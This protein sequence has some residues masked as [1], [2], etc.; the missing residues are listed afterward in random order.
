LAKSQI[1]V[2]ERCRPAIEKGEKLK[3][4][5]AYTK[6]VEEIIQTLNTGNEGLTTSQVDEM[7]TKYGS[8]V[9][10]EVRS[11]SPLKILLQQFN[12]FLIWILL[13]AAILSAILDKAESAIVIAVVILVNAVLGTVQHL[14]AEE[15]LAALK[16]LSSPTAKVIRAGATITIDSQELVVGDILA[17]E[18]GDFIAAD[19][20]IISSFSLK[21]DESALTGESVSVE[22]DSKIIERYDLGPGDQ[23]NMVFSGTH[24]TYGR[25]QAVVTAVGLKTELGKI[26][27][28]LDQAKE[29]K[30]PLQ[31]SLDN[32]GR[33]LAIII[34]AISA[35][36]FAM[37]I[38]RG[39]P[40]L[41]AVMFSVS[42]AV[43]AIPEALSSIVTIVLA[44]GTRKMARENAIIRRLHAVE[45]LGSVSVICSDKTGT[46]TQN[47][48]SVQKAYIRG[49]IFT[50]DALDLDQKQDRSLLEIA[51]LCN[52]SITTENGEIGDPTELALVD[53]GEIY[54]LDE[55]KMRG[56]YKRISELPFD[57]ER[58]LMSTLHEI[59]GKR[60]MVAKGGVDVMLRRVSFIDEGSGQR[61]IT[62]EDI[63]RIER[64]NKQLSSEGL[65]V[66]AFALKDYTGSELE[67]GDE[68]NM[69]IIGLVAMMD[70]P[71]PESKSAVEACHDAGIRTVMITGDHVVT[72]SAIARQ[73]GILDDDSKAVEGSV[74]EKLDDR[75]LRELVSKTSVYARVSPEHKIRI[76]KAWQQ[77]GHAVAMTGDG[78][79]DAPAL[80]QADVGVAMGITGT[81]VSKDAAS[82]VLADDNFATIVKAV[83]N[84]R[85]TY[86]NISNAVQFLL[87]GNAAGLLAVLYASLAGLPAPFA[88]V[89]L[90]FIN[91]VTDSLPAIAIGLEAQEKAVMSE[92]PRDIR[93]PLLNKQFASTV[94]FQGI[95][96]AISTMTAFYLGLV[97]TGGTSFAS[98]NV[99]PAAKMAAATMAFAVLC[100][101]RL[102]HG[103]N[104]KTQG[105]L[106]LKR[107]FSNR[108]SW[109][110]FLIGSG[111]LAAVLFIA[112]LQSVFET[113][114]LTA[115]QYF[116]IVGLALL[117]TVVIQ[118]YRKMRGKLKR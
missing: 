29:K 38:Y 5:Q 51:L 34:L 22:K 64:A 46:L 54:N 57:S 30:T 88:P 113:V 32:F 41:D 15:S 91:L 114:M 98:V 90:L 42:L 6:T 66:L 39:D 81:E 31:R 16:A 95:L 10:G 99:S 50:A 118:I 40:I 60:I 110:A 109:F 43:A 24:I 67:P 106:S 107:L 101:A 77:L 3:M 21:A 85:S 4:K 116:L 55:L 7:R 9:L 49:Q 25:A 12:D 19:G 37:G 79:N 70:P 68:Q 93:K 17:I 13:A 23:S 65:R 35:I 108:F 26:A 20:R 63:A 96:I 115:Q 87:S 80:K 105:P 84:G 1:L 69:T 52:D 45:G 8:N 62:A 53:W 103:F 2:A 58:K 82:M 28:L 73:I 92:L 102:I 44:I 33:K 14:K 59:D 72:A 71:R 11:V 117:P 112:P 36:I 86:R 75:Q 61:Q 111:L 74:I 78:V 27:S 76:V 47:K 56:R 83:S 94:L 97:R 89:H 100:L 104:S 18:T 48:M